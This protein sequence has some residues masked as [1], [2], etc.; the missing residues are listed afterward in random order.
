MQPSQRRTIPRRSR[1]N[2]TT[3]GP[4]IGRR[5]LATLAVAAALGLGAGG[6]AARGPVG[7]AAAGSGG[8]RSA[9]TVRPVAAAIALPDAPWLAQRGDGQWVYGQGERGTVRRLPADETGLAI[10]DRLVAS[11]RAGADG[12]S[13]GRLRDRATGRMTM[14]LAVPIWVSAGAWT[15]AGLVVTG[16][17][18]SA[19]AGD[20]G[21][22]AIDS[23]T[24]TVTVLVAGGPF[25]RALGTPVARGDVLVSPNGDVVASN[26]C[27]LERCDLQ[28]VELASG[29]VH[30]PITGGEGF[31]RALTDDA[32]VTTDGSYRWI[33]ARRI[34]DGSEIWRVRDRALIDPV[35]LGDGAI[36]GLV[37]SDRAGWAI[38]TIDRAG[39]VHDLTA[40]RRGDVLLPRI[41]RG[42]SGRDAL[43]VGRAPFEETLDA[44]GAAVVTLIAPT[45]PKPMAATIHLPA[46]TEAIP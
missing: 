12:R 16:Y 36:A 7:S 32:V 14:E 40:R 46:A 43:V 37:G 20:G 11:T 35:A 3:G 34:R 22:V 21:L 30:R 27:G 1:L 23:D 41:W 8:P 28:V 10:G 38:A 13:I 45:D 29:A 17:G 15:S 24:A 9:T 2:E 33:N 18:D 6:V 39:A 44:G 19:M 42:L 25:S 4:P 31:L 5:S 26:L